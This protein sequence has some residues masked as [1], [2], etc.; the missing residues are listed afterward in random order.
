MKRLLLLAL[1]SFLLL[2]SSAAGDGCP[3]E[4]CGVGAL[5]YPGSSTI[6]LR[7]MGSV[8]G[9]DVVTGKQ[10]F[11]RR[12]PARATDGRAVR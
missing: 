2:P 11:A 10:R 5:A 7:P 9:Y 6:L 3:P 4:Q 8:A 1:L 12:Q